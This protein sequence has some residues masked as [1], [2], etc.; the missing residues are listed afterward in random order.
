MVDFFLANK[1]E[2][3]DLTY[4]QV[5]GSMINTIEEWKENK[6]GIIFNKEDII[7]RGSG[8]KERL[9]IRKK[10]LV[11]SL[12]HGVD[13]F[14][15]RLKLAL[16]R[17]KSMW[18]KRI[19][20]ISDGAVWI[21]NIFRDLLPG[22][23]HVLDW[24]HVTEHLWQTAKLLFGEKSE[25]V[26]PWV[27]KYKELIIS[28]KIE[29]VLDMLIF[30]SKKHKSP[31]PLYDLHGYFKSRVSMMRY[32]QFRAEGLYIGSGAIEAANKYAIQNRLK[33][34]GM[35]WSITGANAIAKLR[36]NYLSDE[37]DSTWHAA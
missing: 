8:E 24:F 4:V 31:T 18:S 30:E 25:K 21:E 12:G 5:D 22:C 19:V 20:I 33:K 11:T 32:D 7:S 37:W 3:S 17:S 26:R 16:F 10:T 34:C 1:D 2:L 15:S 6:L 29:T 28:G 36:T 35:K 23:T 14:K 9:S 27:E 13:D